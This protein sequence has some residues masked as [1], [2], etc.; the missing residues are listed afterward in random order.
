[1]EKFPNL[2]CYPTLPKQMPA[3]IPSHG[4]Q[5]ECTTHSKIIND[6]KRKE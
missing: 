5:E 4:T 2:L 6:N 1:M 3:I